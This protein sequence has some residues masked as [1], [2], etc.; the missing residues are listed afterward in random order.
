[1][2]TVRSFYTAEEAH[3]LRTRLEAANVHAYVVFENHVSMCWL[4]ANALGGVR[5]QVPEDEWGDA[6]EFL[7]EDGD[8]EPEDGYVIHCPECGSSATQFDPAPRE[9]ALRIAVLSFSLGVFFPL[10]FFVSL[11]SLRNQWRCQDCDSAF[12]CESLD[13]MPE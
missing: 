7:A 3:L 11:R 6:L 9:R 8:Q 13:V 2:V 4:I 5:V 10:M 12:D 1:M